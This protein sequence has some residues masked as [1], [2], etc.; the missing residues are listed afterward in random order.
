L[1]NLLEKILWP[2]FPSLA[3]SALAVSRKENGGK[4]FPQFSRETNKVNQNN[5]PFS[6]K[7]F[8]PHSVQGQNPCP[9]SLLRFPFPAEKQ[10]CGPEARALSAKSIGGGKNPFGDPPVLPQNEAGPSGT[11]PGAPTSEY[12]CF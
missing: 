1:E 9:P 12:I 2:I 7:N 4:L 11:Q 5:G 8:P 6:R 3:S 10:T